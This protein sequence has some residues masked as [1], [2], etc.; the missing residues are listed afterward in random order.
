[1]S[2]EKTNVVDENVAEDEK[3]KHGKYMIGLL[4]ACQKAIEEMNKNNF[5]E[6][7]VEI[8]EDA[9]AWYFFGVLS[10][11]DKMYYGKLP[12]SVKKNN[13]EC[14]VFPMFAPGNFLKIS[15]AK[16]IDIPLKY[17]VE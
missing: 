10:S 5:I 14:N 16:Q 15:Q 13:G 2:D 7:F 9:D 17:T 1:M 3:E 11:D 6:G 8:R 4:D 12:Y